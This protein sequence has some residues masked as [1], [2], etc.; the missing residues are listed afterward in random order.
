MLAKAR[1]MNTQRKI[2]GTCP[3]VNEPSRRI[4]MDTQAGQWGSGNPYLK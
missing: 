3:T 2:C 1:A 4:V